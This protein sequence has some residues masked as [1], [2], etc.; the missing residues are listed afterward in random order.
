MVSISPINSSVPAPMGVESTQRVRDIVAAATLA[1]RVAPLGE[2][3][4]AAI[5]RPGISEFTVS[6]GD[7]VVG[8]ANVQP[9][10]DGEP[11]MIEL[12]VD[13]EH[14]QQGH[15]KRLLTTVLGQ[16]E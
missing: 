9:S 8:Y 1:D 11:A 16:V 12:V 7:D 13:P 14:R 2:Q 4:V 5:G 10:R 6:S 15:G 3:A